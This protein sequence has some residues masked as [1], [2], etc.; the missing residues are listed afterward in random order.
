M[1]R[2]RRDPPTP[3]SPAE[4]SPRQGT[5]VQRRTLE[6]LTWS[7]PS[8]AETGLASGQKKAR[9]TKHTKGSQ[10]PFIG[11]SQFFDSQFSM[12]RLAIHQRFRAK[13]GTS[14][15]KPDPSAIIPSLSVTS[16]AEHIPPFRR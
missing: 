11:Q 6:W 10:R 16:S 4:K 15:A 7:S 1:D 8:N 2:A 13:T 9:N 12:P 5:P 3:Q 14:A